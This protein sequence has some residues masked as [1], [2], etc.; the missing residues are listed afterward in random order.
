MRQAT[1]LAADHLP[2]GVQ[3]EIEGLLL[4]P[5][6][7]GQA[8]LLVAGAAH[9][10]FERLALIGSPRYRA[11]GAVIASTD[12]RF[13]ESRFAECGEGDTPVAGFC[14]RLRDNIGVTV[15]ASRFRDCHGCDFIHGVRNARVAIRQ[16][17]FDRAV[18]GRCGQ[19]VELCHHQDLIHL[20]DGRDFV[21]DRNRFGLQFF[22]AAQVY[23]TGA[24]GA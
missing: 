4:T 8:Q 6:G 17:A 10:R 15:R 11:N 12:V 24:S 22:G 7:G 3:V 5:R 19:N 2:F 20:A 16:S 9:V 13:L 21:I 23:L 18:P 14:L 1:G